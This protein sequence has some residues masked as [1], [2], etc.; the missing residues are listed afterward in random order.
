VKDGKYHRIVK[1]HMPGGY[2]LKL[3][4]LSANDGLAEFKRSITLNSHL[5]ERAML[6]VFLHECAH[7]HMRHLG[8]MEKRKPLW[9]QEFEADQYAIKAMRAE[10][11]PLPR[12]QLANHKSVMQ[13]YIVTGHAN[14]D[15]V[16][17]EVLRY[18]YGRDWRKHR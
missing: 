13:E 12:A 17:D 6:F 5:E 8:K 18:A 10:G 15:T 9:L 16:D 7:V 4:A 3:R 14:G 2:E 11:I 1:K